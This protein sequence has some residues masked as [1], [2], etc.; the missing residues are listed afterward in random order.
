MHLRVPSKFILQISHKANKLPTGYFSCE[1]QLSQSKWE[2]TALNRLQTL[3]QWH[4]IDVN[5]VS[6]LAWYILTV[7]QNLWPRWVANTSCL[8]PTKNSW[9]WVFI[10]WVT[11]KYFI[12]QWNPCIRNV[13][14]M[15]NK[16]MK[17]IDVDD[18]NS[19]IFPRYQQTKS[20]WLILLT[21]WTN[22]IGWYYWP[23]EQIWLVDTI[24]RL[25]KS[26][27]SKCQQN[28]V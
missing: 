16:K 25:N 11:R 9:M 8:S 12:A 26:D 4:C 24:D 18:L 7:T 19:C 14:T 2:V 5:D 17:Y 15:W 21:D 23:T 1:L 27:W 6:S 22:L 13:F 3:H 28:H 10:V 20:D